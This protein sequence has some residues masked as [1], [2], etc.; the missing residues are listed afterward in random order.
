V[1]GIYPFNR[2]RRVEV[3][4]G[5]TQYT[6]RFDDPSFEDFSR[7]YQQEQFGRQLFNNGNM[8]PLGVAFTQE[9]TIF[10]EFGPLAGSTARVGFEFAP[11]LGDNTLSRKTFDV[12]ARKYLRIGGSGLLA[13]RA[14]GFKSWGDNPDFLYFG[15]NSEMRGY[16][17]LSFVGQ[18]AFFLNA[19]L[20]FPLIEAMAT[21]IGI[22]GGIRGSFFANIG[23]ASWADS[24]FKAW[25]SGSE[26]VRPILRYEF[27]PNFTNPQPVFDA[28]RL[29]EGFRLVDARGSYGV[30]LQ[31]FAL[32][33]PV[34][35]D[36]AW[37]TL[38]NKDWEDVLFSLQGG[39]GAFRKA[40]FSV[41]I[42]Y[43][44]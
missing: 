40:K 4:G 6:E 24:G 25:T 34:H 16:D 31:T 32:G 35:F 44:F 18:D 21:P 19:E 10:R 13:L 39:S 12:D 42:G 28:P 1:F 36:W 3:Y 26:L 43:D 20:R 29:V 7:Q 22:L 14:R 11:K 37:K 38:F 5:F 33:F 41:W 17:Y 23:G 15:G 9:T 8:L 30:G 2:Y 27:G